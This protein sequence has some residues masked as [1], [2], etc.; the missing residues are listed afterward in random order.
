MQ[1]MRKAK[2]F[3]AS[4]G[5]A[6][7]LSERLKEAL[8]TDFSEAIIWSEE[9]KGKPSNT[10]I[11][12]LEDASKNYDFAIIILTQDDMISKKDDNKEHPKARDNCIFEAGLFMGVLGRKRCFLVSSVETGSLPVDLSGIIYKKIV[13]PEDQ[14]FQGG[15]L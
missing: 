13:E 3:I 7:I 14:P 5:R 8:S 10:I 12:M 6:L 2:I 11:E 9:S 1:N 4:S 15:V